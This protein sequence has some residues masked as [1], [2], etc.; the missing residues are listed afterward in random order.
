VKDAFSDGTTVVSIS[1]E[2]AAFFENYV[3]ITH[4]VLEIGQLYDLYQQKV[5]KYIEYDLDEKKHIVK[6]STGR[7]IDKMTVNELTTGVAWSAVTLLRAIDNFMSGEKLTDDGNSFSSSFAEQ[8]IGFPFIILMKK[9][10]EQGHLPVNITADGV[11]Y[12]DLEEIHNSLKDNDVAELKDIMGSFIEEMKAIGQNIH[13][14]ELYN[15]MRNFLYAF[16]EYY[17]SYYKE[18]QSFFY[19]QV[20]KMNLIIQEHPE[21]VVKD[22]RF[23]DYVVYQ[24]K[25]DEVLHA[26][27]RS[28]DPR[29]NFVG[30]KKQAEE[31]YQLCASGM[32]EM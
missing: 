28:E 22:G 25:D 31:N 2:E 7:I 32:S 6:K 29:V 4:D 12:Y 10:A 21:L 18:V 5:S 26:F 16:A 14:I 13:Q 30:M 1:G 15:M 27:R 17:L 8:Y 19:T 20:E 23:K 24:L 3:K 11:C 9:Y